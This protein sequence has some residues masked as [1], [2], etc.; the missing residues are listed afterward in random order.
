MIKTNNVDG[1]QV[2]AAGLMAWNNFRVFSSVLLWL[3][4]LKD[5]ALFGL[6][7]G[8]ARLF[9]PVVRLKLIS[10]AIGFGLKRRGSLVHIIFQLTYRKLY[11]ILLSVIEVISIQIRSCLQALNF[12]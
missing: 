9:D 5:F 12:L 6:P 7:P 8:G 2:D 4:H 3:W 11:R 10:P 1:R